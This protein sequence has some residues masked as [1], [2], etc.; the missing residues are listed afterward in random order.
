MERRTSPPLTPGPFVDGTVAALKEL[1]T[2]QTFQTGNWEGRMLRIPAL[3][4]QAVWAHDQADAKDLIQ[5]TQP[6]PPFL[7]AGRWYTWD[8]LKAAALTE[9]SSKLE[10]GKEGKM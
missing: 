6:V 4:L 2:D 7:T 3:Y 9:A 5:V 1:E 8:E 10:A